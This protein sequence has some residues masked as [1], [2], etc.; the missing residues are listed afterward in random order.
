MEA[1]AV[2]FPS[3]FFPLPDR[4]SELS[5]LNFSMRLDA[6]REGNE[7]LLVTGIFTLLD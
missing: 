2:M 6:N 1:L 5:I 3:F 7:F 4:T